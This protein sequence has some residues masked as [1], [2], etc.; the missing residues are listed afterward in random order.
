MPEDPL[1]DLTILKQ[2]TGND[3]T[4]IAEMISLFITQMN[5]N[6]QILS[7]VSPAADHQQLY[8]T[9]HRMKAGIHLFKIHT[10]TDKIKEAEALAKAG[11]TSVLLIN[12]IEIICDVMRKCITQL[13][14]KYLPG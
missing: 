8:F 2:Q 12:D 11:D 1:Y 7:R 4:F 14:D 5:E 6:V 13:K 9:L 3:E 10:L